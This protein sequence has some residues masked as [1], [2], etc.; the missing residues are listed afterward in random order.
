MDIGRDEGRESERSRWKLS[1]WGVC[2]VERSWL[3][4]SS[5]VA[6]ALDA[7]GCF[8][9]GDAGTGDAGPGDAPAEGG[10]FW[11]C[12]EPPHCD[13]KERTV[14]ERT[15]RSISEGSPPE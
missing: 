7:G 15:E 5:A 9:E 2:E 6:D 14:A 12:V 11:R 13:I 10:F 8:A 4:V 1:R 3:Y